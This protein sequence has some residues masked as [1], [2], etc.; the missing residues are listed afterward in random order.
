MKTTF[1]YKQKFSLIMLNF[2]RISV[3]RINLSKYIAITNI[4]THV[5]LEKPV[6]KIKM[7]FG[8]S[9]FLIYKIGYRKPIRQATHKF[10]IKLEVNFTEKNPRI[11]WK[12]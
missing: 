1:T 10:K 12:V 7:S 4:G 11:W 5:K 3:V 2:I 6:K 8:H 9:D